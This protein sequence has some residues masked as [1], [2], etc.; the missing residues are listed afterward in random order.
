MM[1]QI[2][3]SRRGILAA[4]GALV[5]RFAA[6][7][8]ATAQTMAKG[9]MPDRLSSWLAVQQNGEVVAYFGKI[10]VGQGIEVAIGQI[11]AEELDVSFDRVRVVMGDTALTVNQGGASG[12]TG[13]ELGGVPMRFAAA[14]ARRVLLDMAAARLGMPAAS[15]TVADGVV[16][17]GDRR[18]GYG[19]LIGGRDFDVAMQWNGVLGN[20]LTARGVAQ[21]KAP[22]QYRLV[23]TSVPR[24]D[25]ARKVFGR[26]VY[27]GDIRLPGM[28]HGRMIRPPV[29]GSTVVAVD[30]ASVAHLKGVRVVRNG[31]F[32]AVV[33]PR[34]WDAIRASEALKVTWSEVP[35]PFP[36]QDRLHAHIRTA[37]VLGSKAEFD[38]GGVDD[39][40]A[41]AGAVITAEY[42]WPFQSHASMAPACAVADVRA[43]GI[44]VW[45]GTQK[46]HY[47]QL[48]V[49]AILGR[50]PEEVHAIW[51]HGPGSY[52]RNDAGDAVIDAALLSKAMGA[53]VRVQ[54]MRHEGTGWDPKG[55]ASVHVGRAAL[56]ASGQMVALDFAT[57]A[58]SRTDIDSNES[59]P[60]HSL[61]GQ[62]TG[63]G[64]KHGPAFGVPE[65][66]YAVPAKRLSWASVAP[67]LALASPLRTSHL[68]DPVGPQLIFGYESFIDEVAFQA[69]A[70]PVA[71]RLRHLTDARSRDVV[72]AAAE[73]FGW[74]SR[75][76]ASQVAG[77][78][79]MTGRG[80]AFAQRGRTLVAVIVELTVHRATGQVQPVRYVVAHECGLIINPDGLRR[81]IEGN[82]LHA[83]SRSLHE[84]VMFDRNNVTSVDW[85][86]YPILDIAE[87]PQAIDIVLLDRPDRP[88][89]GAGEA[90]TRP[91]AA[92]I[93][94]A[95]FDATGVRLRQAPFTA[96]RMKAAMGL[97][98]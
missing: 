21:P 77:G 54:G 43:D 48:G 82:I 91:V 93:A 29:A 81:T 72:K 34:E 50:R 76:A 70:D 78:D 80:I 62:M 61:A 74:Q 69:K 2:M 68:R 7:R 86:T 36:P 87:A 8:C 95:I 24:A 1:N 13:I 22:S 42:E 83:T 14:E 41:R 15:L 25:V 65:G 88:A 53:P 49:A 4:G 17:G 26:R 5:V 47:A 16:A 59:N 44:T 96:D 32:L 9:R 98:V 52:G 51:T 58:F 27:V 97:P 20:G 45:T 67:L 3:L 63:L 23:G 33:A 92:A 55:P 39:V 66:A 84:E 73:K 40:L 6:P 64:A 35:P 19:E 46:P 56:D 38:Q 89:L 75:V 71:F 31:A 60:R 37:Q 85:L 79:L 12:S 57:R 11:V 94:N 10:D 30:E 18:V 90:S 28:L